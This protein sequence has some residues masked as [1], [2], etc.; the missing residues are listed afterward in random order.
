MQR[1]ERDDDAAWQAIVANYGERV[2]LDASEGTDPWPART[3]SDDSWDDGT[4]QPDGLADDDE[5]DD[6]DRLDDEGFVPPPAPPVPVPG[7]DRMIAW[8]GVLGSPVVLLVLLAFRVAVPA[9][10]ACVL[11]GGFVL[12]FCYLVMRMPGSP[13][14]PWD[15]GAR[16]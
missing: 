6:L 13:R 1:D 10:L 12:G 9:W 11:V 3:P 2:E 7:P 15:D 4:D 16:L 14:D 5:L 8:T